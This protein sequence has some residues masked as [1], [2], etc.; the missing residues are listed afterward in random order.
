MTASLLSRLR[1]RLTAAAALATLATACAPMTQPIARA[2]AG[3]AG[4]ALWKVADE[5]TTIYLFGTV[6]ALPAGKDWMRPAIA[7]ALAESDTLVTEV[8]LD[9]TTSGALQQSVIL[10]GMLPA[11]QNL[12]EMLTADD[13]AKYEAAVTRLGL[14]AET[15]DRFE[16][17]YAAMMLT[18]LPLIKEGYGADAGAE[19][20]LGGA[21]GE[22]KRREALETV[23]YQLS[24]FDS[25]PQEAQV[26]YLMEV[27]EGNENIKALLDRMV[28]EWLAG[29][30]DGLAELI[31]EGLTDADL[32]D[33]LLYQRNRNWADWIAER[34]KRPGTVFMAVGAGHLAGENSVQ[35]ALALRG[36][37]AARVP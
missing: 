29:D 31:N 24:I 16:P 9:D 1:R 6:H 21:A 26:R 14:K 34:L 20:V 23:D 5:D 37:A 3:P 22:S 12:R 4:P 15:F 32:A 25:L 17:W 28:A 13:R 10:K 19:K 7:D 18:M 2:P 11:E 35:D 33:K 8:E 36:I 27:V 30:A